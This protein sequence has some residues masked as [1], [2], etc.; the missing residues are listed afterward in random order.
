M[1]SRI[2]CHG[3]RL[4]LTDSDR[5]LTHRPARA[6]LTCMNLQ[7]VAKSI[8]NFKPAKFM[9]VRTG[10]HSSSIPAVDV[11]PFDIR[12]RMQPAAMQEQLPRLRFS[13]AW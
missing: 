8:S 11:Q 6:P 10:A 5:A 4:D 12:W 9:H 1:S 3:G 2:R 13:F 7:F